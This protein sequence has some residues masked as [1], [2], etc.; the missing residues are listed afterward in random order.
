VIRALSQRYVGDFQLLQEKLATGKVRLETATL[1]GFT[2]DAPVTRV[3]RV[4]D[5]RRAA[6][7]IYSGGSTLIGILDGEGVDYLRPIRGW[8]P[9][10]SAFTFEGHSY[11][12]GMSYRDY[13]NTF[14]IRFSKPQQEIYISKSYAGDPPPGE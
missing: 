9:F 10:D 4:T 3:L 13:D 1:V 12:F 8:W 7:D 11:L 6:G 14:K 2:S 5:D